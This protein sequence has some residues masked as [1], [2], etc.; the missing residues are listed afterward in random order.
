MKFR[1]AERVPADAIGLICNPRSRRNAAGALAA[2]EAVARGHRIAR[3][4]AADAAGMAEALAE[5]AARDAQLVVVCGGDGTAQ[6]AF[7]VLAGA[8]SPFAQPPALAVL[9]GG[10]SNLTPRAAGN[11]GD[12]ARAF[13][14]LLKAWPRRVTTREL[15]LLRVEDAAG[16]VRHGLL[17]LAGGVV[18][19]VQEC[20]D[21]RA[22][23]SLPLLR[24][25]AGTA[26]WLAGALLRAAAG[27]AIV[28]AAPGT[29]T[30]DDEPLPGAAFTAVLAT[31]LE[32][33]GP[34]IRPWWGGS[35]G[36]L[37]MTAV[38]AGAR[39]GLRAMP[40]LLRGRP[41]GVLR[42][43]NGYWS[44]TPATARVQ[45]AGGYQLDG[46]D[47]AS[48]ALSLAPGMVLSVVHA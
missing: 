14:R 2:V 23:S 26:V 32:R 20:R 10:R 18:G 24:G 12:P 28:P 22:M 45:L 42:A 39:H 33:L 6:A 13:A 29:V 35:G 7:S 16:T 11:G 46:E 43:M 3:L 21:F 40:R 19:A 44:G 5:L 31:T 36:V 17:V 37:R 15:P 25:G 34:G 47:Y 9:A 8:T 1:P 48:A 30:A 38:R 41:G 4:H 27:H